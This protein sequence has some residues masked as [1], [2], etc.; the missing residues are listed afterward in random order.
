MSSEV[1][2]E[3][4]Q[5][6]AFAQQL[7]DLR[8]SPE[9]ARVAIESARQQGITV[10]RAVELLELYH[11]LKVSDRRVNVGWLNRWLRGLSIPPEQTLSPNRQLGQRGDA[12]TREQVRSIVD[13]SAI[14]RAG[15]RRGLTDNQILVKLQSAGY[16]KWPS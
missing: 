6:Q 5:W 1:E 10:A 8:M 15:R 7:I 9:G 12:L 14:I 2:Q 11:R 3:T 13:S 16:P 4:K